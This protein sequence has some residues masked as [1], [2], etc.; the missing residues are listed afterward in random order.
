MG[1]HKKVTGAR[2]FEAWPTVSYIINQAFGANPDRYAQY[3]FPGHE[4]IDIH[5]PIDSPYFAVL[6]GVVVWA[7][8]QRRSGGESLYG[9]HIIIDHGDG[10]TTLYAHAREDIP[11]AVGDLVYPGDII[12]YS[13][14]TGNSTGPHLHLTVKEEGFIFPGWSSRPGY[15]DPMVYLEGLT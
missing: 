3:G 4:G 9:Y 15:N 13:G 11:V 2:P 10:F 12:G 7:S 8:N 14:N 1:I 5:A 6:S